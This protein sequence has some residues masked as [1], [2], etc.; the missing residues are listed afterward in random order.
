M[1]LRTL[2]PPRGIFGLPPTTWISDDMIMN[3]MPVVEFVPSKPN[4]DTGQNVF[5]VRPDLNAYN[6]ILAAHGFALADPQHI[7]LAFLADNFPTDT[8]SNDYGET[9][10]Q[11]MTDISSQGIQDIIQIS[12]Q[13]EATAG[14]KALLGTLKGAAGE[15]AFGSAIKKG[16]QAGI[17]MITGLKESL[18]EMSKPGAGGANNLLAGSAN[19]VDKLL[20]GHRVDFP[21]VWRNSGYSPSYTMTIRLYNPKPGSFDATEQWIIGPLIAILLLGLPRSLDGRNYSWPFFHRI[22]ATGLY[23]LDPG[24]IT[25]IT[26]IKGGDQQQIAYNQALAMVDVRIDITSLFTTIIAEESTDK[27]W[28]NRPTLREYMFAM[29]TTTDVD[30]EGFTRRTQLRENASIQSDNPQ[31]QRNVLAGNA[32]ITDRLSQAEQQ[33]YDPARAKQ[34]SVALEQGVETRVDPNN[35][36]KEVTLIAQSDPNLVEVSEDLAEDIA[37]E[38]FGDIGVG[39]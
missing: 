4:F 25:N 33:R 36:I 19:M 39:A 5:E 12:G 37:D 23:E 17:D 26:V 24:V 15:G 13:R 22:T 38:V 31:G 32:Q 2:N 7:K 20:G 8:F 11:K 34:L 30:K 9:F 10:L 27:P 35:L 3:S 14:A 28:Q 21:S 29:R 6:K 16:S 18:D 1:A